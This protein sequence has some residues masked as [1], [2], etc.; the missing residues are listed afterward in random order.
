MQSLAV[1]S[2]LAPERPTMLLRSAE[3]GAMVGMGSCHSC[4]TTGTRANHSFTG[5]RQ[6]RVANITRV[7]AALA[8]T[9]G[10]AQAQIVGTF[11]GGGALRASGQSGIGQPVTLTFTPATN[12]LFAVPTLDGIFSPI[13]PGT[14]GTVQ[15]ITVGTGVYNV[16]D[17]ITIGGYTFSL[18]FVAPGS[19]SPANCLTTPAVAGQ[20]C[21]P[22]NTPFNLVNNDNGHGG[23]SSSAAFSVSGFVTDPSDNT[24]AYNGIFTSQFT[25]TSYQQLIAQIDG[26]STIPVSYSL[27]IEATSL[28][29]PE[30][31]TFALMGAG[32]LALGGVIRVRRSQV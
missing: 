19:F 10:V 12:N 14:A 7:V 32:L 16:A 29:T 17:F 25:N 21:S 13:A 9:A 20:T 3:L 24:Y 8:L 2:Y 4:V 1:P 28:A 30:P 31:A 15:T 27:T 6:M 5:V 23:V 11:N 22:P 26:G 18:N